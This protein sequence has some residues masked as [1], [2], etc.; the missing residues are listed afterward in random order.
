MRRNNHDYEKLIVYEG[1]TNP[2]KFSN[3][4]IYRQG[5]NSIGP[6]TDESGVLA[7]DS[8]HMPR[9][10]NKMFASVFMI[11]NLLSAFRGQRSGTSSIIIPRKLT[12][13][14]N[15]NIWTYLGSLSIIKSTV[16]DSLSPK[17]LKK[18]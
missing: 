13:H 17:F 18:D 7:K 9:I 15:M 3:A 5:G 16:T 14:T 11:D 8:M 2:K 1:K 4:L 10:L 12:Q 6:L